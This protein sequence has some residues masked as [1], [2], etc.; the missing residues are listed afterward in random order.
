MLSVNFDFDQLDI[1]AVFSSTEQ[2]LKLAYRRAMGK[3]IR[4][5]STRISRELGQKF[6]LPQRVFQVR[7]KRNID[8]D[9]GRLWIGLN[10][11]AAT[12][13]GKARQTKKGVSVRSHRFNGAFI[14][15][16]NSGHIGVF[17]RGQRQ[18]KGGN[19]Y[20]PLETV[21]AKMSTG[22]SNEIDI[23]IRDYQS[24]ATDYFKK[25]LEHEL[26]YIMQKAAA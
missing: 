16:M 13:L 6:D 9:V 23:N 18:I 19:V 3:T 22:T 2:Q 1:T 7:A 11:I 10:P 26:N 12:Y 20:Y 4:W 17:Q 24:R 25:T 8:G 15:K 5:L 21:K 14:A